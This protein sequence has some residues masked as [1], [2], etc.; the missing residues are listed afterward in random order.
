MLVSIQI[1]ANKP[2]I[3][4]VK[5]IEYYQN[6]VKRDKVKDEFENKDLLKNRGETSN[7]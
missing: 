5:I 7:V 4:K 6:I 1:F 3:I 2:T